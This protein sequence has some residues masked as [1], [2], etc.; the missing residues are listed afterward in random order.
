MNHEWYAEDTSYSTADLFCGGEPAEAMLGYASPSC[1]SSQI[2]ELLGE[3]CELEASFL[4]ESWTSGRPMTSGRGGRKRD[5]AKEN[6]EGVTFAELSTVG[7]FF[8]SAANGLMGDHP[9]YAYPARSM[10][11]YTAAWLR[12]PLEEFASRTEDR[13]AMQDSAG[14]KRRA[15]VPEMLGSTTYQRACELLSVSE[16][17]TLTQI[18]AAYRRM[19]SEWHPDRLEQTDER[20]RAFATKQ[21]AAINEAYHLLRELSPAPAC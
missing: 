20:V 2:R 7:S 11:S 16:D 12:D 13:A 5:Q 19:V 1:L 18:R 4:E 3:D 9:V 21:M 14:C 10:N 8:F 15:Y 17:S 6:V